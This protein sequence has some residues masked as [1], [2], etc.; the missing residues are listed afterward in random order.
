MKEEGGGERWKEVGGKR[1]RRSTERGAR[2]KKSL[3]ESDGMKREMRAGEPIIQVSFAKE[4]YQNGA[5][6]QKGQTFCGIYAL[7]WHLHIAVI[8]YAT[9]KRARARKR[10]FHTMFLNNVQR[11]M[12]TSILIGLSCERDL[13]KSS[14]FAKERERER[15]THTH[16]AREGERE[17]ANAD[18]CARER[19][20]YVFMGWLRLVGSL[21][22]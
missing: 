9:R 13:L 11:A 3:E 7:L 18:A 5:F 2:R 19:T 12:Q 16:R 17:N 10:I 20:L 6:L 21:K 22:L 15:E 1:G 8:P 14:S 4:T